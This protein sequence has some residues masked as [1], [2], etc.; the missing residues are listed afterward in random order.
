MPQDSFRSIVYRSFVTCDDPKGVVECGT[1]RRSKSGAEKME[2]K[3]ESSRKAQS[4]SSNSHKAERVELGT[5]GANEEEEDSSSSCQLM[6]VSRGAHKLN[7][8]IDSWSKGL[9]YDGHSKDIAKDL[10]KGA[11]DLQESLHMLGKLQEASHYMARLKKKEKEKERCDRVRNDQVLQRTNSSPIV[12]RNYQTGFQNPRF[13]AD[14]VSRDCIE[15]LRKVIKEGLARQ[16]QLP[17]V[18]AEEKRCFSRRYSDSTSDI[19]S[20]SSSHSSTFQTDNFTSMDSSISSAALD[21]KAR[22]PSL[23]A[24]LMGLEEMPSKPLQTDSQRE[25]DSK[26][27]FSQ[28]RPIFEIDMP[29]VRKSHHV[30]KKKDPERRTLKEILET[31]HFK[32]LLRSNSMIKEIKYE[33]HHQSNDFFSEQSLINDNPPI[34]LIKPRHVPSLQPEEK[35][36]LVFQEEGS[37]NT[38]TK[39]KKMKVKEEPSS[40][41]I[42]SKNRGLIFNEK[43]GRAEAEETPTPI[44]RLSQQEVAKDSQ[45]KETITVKK[46]VKTK[47]KVSIKMKSSGPVTLPSPKK[48]ANDRKSDKT[49]KPA[50][51][52]KKPVEKEVAKA[53]NLSRSKDQAK[54]TPPKL[55]KPEN[56]S[57]VSK[58]KISRPRSATT[59][60]SKSNGTPQ[61]ANSKSNHMP[62]TI[63]GS[64]S[65]QKKS[66]TKKKKPV[67]KAIA[68]KKTTEKLE[69]KG[70][71]EKIEVASENVNK[72]ECIGDNKKIDLA[73]ENDN[74]FGGYSN[75][76]ADQLS[77]EEGTEHTDIQIEEH[78]DKGESLALDVTP[79]T[80]EDQSNRE[81]IGEFDDDPIIP[82]GPDS[83]SFIVETGLKALLLSSPTFL[84]HAEELFDLNVNVPTTSQKFGIS[85]ITD[86]NSRLL[87]DCANEIVQ[88]RSFPDYQMVHPPLLTLVGN[89]K[90]HS[91]SLAHLLKETCDSIEALRRY[92]ELASENYPIDSLYAMLE[93]DINCSE[94]LSSIWD[95]GWRKG[96]S[97]D[98]KMQ[99]VDDIEKQLLSGLIEEICA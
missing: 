84:N 53:M 44:K 97:V 42:D 26:K 92:S 14:N 41:I 62:R 93:R 82:K 49:A 59:A 6:E 80:I 31:M 72:L 57:N 88:R 32:G 36:S 90:S 37:S 63:V 10:L 33:Y 96:F 35:S 78:H 22:A 1:I 7:K 23:I 24:K 70:G 52:S 51:S 20:T 8:V 39:M 38:E 34:V 89:A 25:I 50:T 12:E 66:P 3:H 4:R 58:N 5:K 74:L 94:V 2:Q 43:S 9:W 77:T 64:A 21:K 73:S 98:D 87:L 27:I 45:E 18:N 75:E 79:V 71:N 67:S 61:I 60:N 48:E 13:S 76:T 83:E 30:N 46:E 91:I 47:Q 81:S 86:A 17:N 56:A 68:A 29:K 40:K 85:D 19:P 55:S 11:L 28:Q 15:E 99:V 69:C 54:V 95:L 65:D 16:N